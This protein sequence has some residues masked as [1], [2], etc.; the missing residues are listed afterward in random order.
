MMLNSKLATLLLAAAL[1]AGTTPQGCRPET[2]VA[3][4]AD[5]ITD[6]TL[7]VARSP[8]GMVASASKLATEVGARVLAAGGNA[9]DAAAATSF[10]LAVVEPAMSGLG[11]RVNMVI[12][13]PNGDF[14][15]IDG[16]NQV[17]WGYRDGAPAGYATAAIPGMPAALTMAVE[18][19]GTRPLAELLEPA[20]RLAEEGFPLPA[21]EAAR[22]AAVVETLRSHEG[23][24]RYFLK[25]DG[26]PYQTGERFVQPDLAKTLRAIA[27]GGAAGFYHGW[28]ADS[29][30][31]HMVRHGG[32][33]TRDEL[34][35]YEALPAILVRGEY[36]DHP[37]VA[38]FR[39]AAGH[40]VVLAL[41][42]L[43]HFDLAP[44][45]GSPAW[46]AITGQAMQLAMAERGRRLGTEEESA[47]SLTA[48]S[49]AAEL[50]TQ[51]RVPPGA[52]SA[53]AAWLDIEPAGTVATLATSAPTT[54]RGS[55]DAPDV[56][57]TTH[58]STAD[59]QGTVVA[60]TQSLGPSMGTRL[61]AP[62]AG[63]LYATRLGST[64][65][66]R[67]G[68]TISPTIVLNPD[69]QPAF[70]L[71]GAGDAR[72]ITAVI[73]TI[74]RVL[75]QGLP[76]HQAMAAPRVHPLSMTS[77]RAEQGTWIAW[78][79]EEL[80]QLAEYGFE[81]STSPSNYF[82]RVHAVGFDRQRSEI[83]GAAEPR[84]TGSAAGPLR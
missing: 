1:L 51:I 36:R 9:V 54:T 39:P 42:I 34:A 12:R 16:L 47:A 58:L 41:Q 53:G 38:T 82:G 49:Y 73:Q 3:P 48:R 11:G 76:L 55:W 14:V 63:F 21:S 4:L 8:H 81:I 31:A 80:R 2:T 65:G 29:I 75:D 68:S 60:L 77:L 52:G 25:P 17:P 46:A 13:L 61:A 26:S 70:A 83:V 69:G 56:E 59:S 84:G 30:H 57:S 32:F 35:Q 66:S 74:S 40:S 45:V 22:F 15:G 7:Q 10:A 44:I 19:F 6:P 33:I 23:S 50:A 43:E 62:G 79:V 27:A 72:I 37:L 64:P 71:G 78:S 18:R 5:G 28:V 20:I 67:P 24:S